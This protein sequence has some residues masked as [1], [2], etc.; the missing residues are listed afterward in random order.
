MNGV[1]SHFHDGAMEPFSMP[2]AS[3][4]PGA[5]AD[6]MSG[7]SGIGGAREPA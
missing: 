7:R 6:A 2:T 1:A 4:P 5:L 3:R